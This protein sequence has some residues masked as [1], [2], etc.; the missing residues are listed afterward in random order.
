MDDTTLAAHDDALRA[1]REAVKAALTGDGEGWYRPLNDDGADWIA[2]DAARAAITAFLDRLDPASLVPAMQAAALDGQR[3]RFSDEYGEVVAR[4][5][6]AQLR[7]E[8]A[9]RS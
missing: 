4:A 1:A 2:D 5:A 9:Q 3:V 6:L 7:K 8:I